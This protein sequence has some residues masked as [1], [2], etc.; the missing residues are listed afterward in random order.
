MK[1]QL[2]YTFVALL[3]IGCYKDVDDT[4]PP[5]VIVETTEVLINT[6]IS[7]SVFDSDGNLVS[8]YTLMINNE[9]NTIPSN[10]F[11]LQFEDVKKKGQTIHVL[12]NGQKIGIRTEL[13]VENDINHLEIVRHPEFNQTS[14]LVDNPIIDF[15]K[16]LKADFSSTQWEYDY[17]G[18][19]TIDYVFIESNTS[20][21]P[22]G[23]S[24][25][26]EVLV[27]D[28][29][30]GFYLNVKNESGQEVLAQKENPILIQTGGLE[31]DINSLFVFDSENE[32]WVLVTEFTPGDEVAVLGEGYYT[33]A[34][35]DSGVFVEG[36][37]TKANSA[38]SYQSMRWTL[39]SFSNEM[40][41]TEEGIWIGL[42]PKE[43]SVNLNFLTPCNISLQ[44]EI[45][46]TSTSDIK[47]QY[48]EIEDN[49]NYQLMN[50]KV[51]NCEEELVA[52]PS[53][54][55][56]SGEKDKF[57][58]FSEGYA[59][60][61][62][63]VCDQFTI[64]AVNQNTDESGP[65]ISW[66]TN[67]ADDLEVLTDCSEL[68]DGYSSIKIRDDERVYASF[69][70]EIVGEKTVLQ[71]EDGNVRF[72]FKGMDEGKYEMDEVNVF[73]DDINFG[74][75]GYYIKCENSAEGC[76]IDYFNVTHFNIE[77]NG[78]IR[79]AFSG[80]LWMQTLSPSVAGNFDV[81]GV[82]VI[83]L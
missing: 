12:K 60:K 46:Q 51:V 30:G 61:W 8:G 34:N 26:S 22:V 48:F 69:N 13:L 43:E 35:Y 70:M 52:E 73:I 29:R 55:I 56:N 45:I 6:S 79:A 18:E 31:E 74:D 64:S 65:E 24:S 75:K 82:I 83:K 28:S 2:L 33:F 53:F 71:S 47:N 78:M 67:V 27:V 38:V 1:K 50:L 19:V 41:A 76:G 39:G 7:G 17:K 14:L 15:T 54:A 44:S 9:L 72:Y 10:H 4:P 59:E 58:V 21:T 36:K 23:Y 49:S 5:E 57:Y 25:L 77:N 11:L 40:C 66:S 32:I 16:S 3:L 62:I 42:M 37:I 80:N 20:L 63:A 81:E 68:E